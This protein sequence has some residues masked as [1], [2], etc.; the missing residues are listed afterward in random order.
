[1]ASLTR[2]LARAIVRLILPI[3]VRG[4]D[5]ALAAGA[6]TLIVCNYT[7]H[8]DGLLLYLFLQTKP[9]FVVSSARLTRWYMR[10]IRGLVDVVPID[11]DDAASVKHIVD[12]LAGTRPVVLFPEGRPTPSG[13]VGKVYE[14]MAVAAEKA[15]RILPVG[16]DGPQHSVFA[17]RASTLARRWRP[18]VRLTILPAT[19]LDFPGEL[20]GA[21][22][23]A[24]AV[25]RLEGILLDASRISFTLDGTIFEALIESLRVHGNS[26]VAED[27]QRKPLSRRMLM[28]RAFALGGNIAARTR[29]GEHVGVMLPNA[30]GVCVVYMA[31][32]GCGRVPAML[33]FTAGVHALQTA[34]QTAQIKVIYT[35]R[36]FVEQAG[37]GDLIEAMGR[38]AEIIYLE[39]VAARISGGKRLWALMA[40]FVPRW[41]YRH[42]TRQRDPNGSAVILFTS[43]SEGVPKGVVLSHRNVLSNCAQ[44]QALIGMHSRDIVFNVLP[45]FH[46]FG[47]TAG[48]LLPLLYGARTFYY[49]TPLHYRIIPE[50]VYR[51]GATILFGTNTF[52]SAYAQH[53]HPAD[54]RS[55]RYVIAGAEKLQAETRRIWSEQFGIRILEGYGATEASPVVS[56]NT[57]LACKAGSVGRLVSGMEGRLEPV[58]GITQGGRLVIRGPNVMR[59]YLYHG[60]DGELIPPVAA[61]GPGWYD[62][63]DIVDIDDEGYLYIIGR[64]KRFAKIGGEM[65]SLAVVEEV[66]TAAWPARLHA[67]VSVAD[68]RKGEAIVL[69][70]EQPDADRRSFLAQA[71]KLGVSELHVPRRFVVTAQMPVLGTGKLDYR[72]VDELVRQSPGQ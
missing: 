63:G 59:G 66:A 72:G 65:I 61:P 3:E 17:C 24:A 45:V 11:I 37:L 6:G 22:R 40:A 21:A 43:G 46:S 69:V 10:L 42:R 15:P 48:M 35:A 14:G 56:V 4:G 41:T 53:A 64:A 60:S 38:S 55:L 13:L 25:R 57:P 1:M 44:A 30:A 7:S 52:L 31:I 26:I 2:S 19:E 62:T 29:V 12:A 49:P 71:Q 5:N 32:H 23:R 70:T 18:R 54:F 68:S 34:I 47:M 51:L 67:A 16:L 8:I 58:E 27:M 39:D 28:A 36:R 33:N 9:V 20:R 50:M